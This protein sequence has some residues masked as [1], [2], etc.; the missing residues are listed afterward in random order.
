MHLWTLT[1][2]GNSSMIPPL[3]AATAAAGLRRSWQARC[4]MA[5]N[6]WAMATADTAMATTILFFGNSDDDSKWRAVATAACSAASA[7]LCQRQQQ[8]FRLRLRWQRRCWFRLQRAGTVMIPASAPA[9]SSATAVLASA[10][11][12]EYDNDGSDNGGGDAGICSSEWV[13]QWWRQQE[14]SALMLARGSDSGDSEGPLPHSG[15]AS[16]GDSERLLPR[17]GSN[18]DHERLR[19][20][21]GFDDGWRLTKCSAF[22]LE[23]TGR[24]LESMSSKV[25]NVW[26]FAVQFVSPYLLYERSWALTTDQVQQIGVNSERTRRLWARA[27]ISA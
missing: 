25:A 5:S 9:G 3:Q 16:G 20:R 1:T 19:A 24:A 4:T 13:R 10:P 18:G 17:S 12:G 11:V 23:K 22:V 26:A 8:R 2:L 21:S 6:W 27:Q 15:D 14:T 7:L